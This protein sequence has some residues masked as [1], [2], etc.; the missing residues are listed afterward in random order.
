[1]RHDYR[2]FGPVLLAWA[3]VALTLNVPEIATYLAVISL[4]VAGCV[5]LIVVLA[6]RTQRNLKSVAF[7]TVFLTLALFGALAVRIS[8]E[9]A[10][11]NPAILVETQTAD[12]SVAQ[13]QLYWRAVVTSQPVKTSDAVWAGEDTS[14]QFSAVVTSI[15]TQ[16][17]RLTTSI[18]VRVVGDSKA[19]TGAIIGSTL[20]FRGT[21]SELPPPSS[22]AYRISARDIDVSPSI[23]LLQITHAM[24]T[25]L[26]QK[27]SE[28]DGWGSELVPG[29][30]VGDTSLVTS[31]LDEAMKTASLS[32]LTAVSGA[33]CAIIT[34]LIL[35]LGTV[36]RW[37]RWVRVTVATAFL[38]VFVTLVTPEPSVLRA[39]VMSLVA[40]IALLWSRK[41]IGVPALGL[42]TFVLLLIDPWQAQH[43]GFVLSVLA[44]AGIVLFTEPIRAL[45]QRLLP[46][47]LS[48]AIAVPFAAQ[49]ACQP[50][51][52]LLQPTLPTFGV[53]ANVL[54][55]PA[56]PLATITGLVACVFVPL[57]PTVGEFVTWLTWFP[58]TYIAEL[59]RFFA[60]LPV[61]QLPWLD[62]WFG[63]LLLASIT[64]TL[65]AFFLRPSVMLGRGSGSARWRAWRLIATAFALSVLLAISVVRP[66]TTWLLIPPNWRIFVCDVGQGDAV[67]VRGS[68]GVMLIDTGVDPKNIASCL[69]V[70]GISSVELLV[71]THDDRDHAG[72]V[73]GIASLVER[74]IISPPV[75]DE[76]RHIL[77]P[78]STNRIPTEVATRGMQGNLGDLRWQVL[79]PVPEVPPQSTNDASVVLSVACPE[80]TA[81][82]LGDLGQEAQDKLHRSY[83][84][85]PVDVVKVSHHGSADQS[86]QLYRHLDAKLGLISVGR[87][88]G[89]GHPT[90]AT[91]RTLRES[92]TSVL[93]TDTQGAIAIARES[94]GQWRIW[95]SA[96]VG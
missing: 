52:I 64:A 54:A 67:L 74:A 36:L 15:S 20:D 50:A 22:A 47:W 84:F 44:T 61:A 17:T 27:A 25:Q 7:L 46:S 40:M 5:L 86:P 70:V 24:R 48:L 87:E 79:W 90:N 73:A 65:V 9:H 14:A 80:L 32:H 57:I 83:S 49:I 21:A 38:A 75:T 63:A 66:V 26:Q 28:L 91:L 39:S 31:E 3:G 41:G 96:E 71:L 92:Q 60:G 76:P 45:L 59:A 81:L 1:M 68:A 13:P 53:L 72:G 88:N 8:A 10:L 69:D 89:Y 94:D 85:V 6:R 23:P 2:F 58:A 42:A 16:E 51:I 30:A 62:G 11:R 43:L 35:A 93:R 19:L 34:G 4:L 29:L 33:N 55:A 77:Q 78:L 37:R 95:S 12:G 56:A 18:P 82:F